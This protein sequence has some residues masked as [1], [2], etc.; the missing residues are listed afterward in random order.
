MT[1]TK[2]AYLKVYAH[3]ATVSFSLEGDK[4]FGK[5]QEVC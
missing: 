1:F 4:S 2:F 5:L 3:V